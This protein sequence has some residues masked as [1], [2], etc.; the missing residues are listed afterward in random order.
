MDPQ[1]D[2]MLLEGTNLGR[3]KVRRA[4]SEAELTERVSQVISA[5]PGIV[6]TAFPGQNIDR[7]VTFYK[8]TKK[9]RRTFVADLYLAHLLRTLGRSTLPD[10]TSGTMRV[11]LPRSMKLRV[12]RDR[13]SIWSSPSEITAFTP[14]SWEGGLSIW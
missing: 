6:L 12:V 11:Y 7:F 14:K 5:T 8:A 10:P 2:A 9:A 4:E 3:E 1:V 13:C